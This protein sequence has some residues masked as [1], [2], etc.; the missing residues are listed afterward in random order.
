MFDGFAFFLLTVC[1][2][3]P[4]EN[5]IVF[6]NASKKTAKKKAAQ[7]RMEFYLIVQ[8]KYNYDIKMLVVIYLFS[9]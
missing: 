1:V 6:L 5:F 8:L 9:I 4:A 7:N 2:R 3:Y